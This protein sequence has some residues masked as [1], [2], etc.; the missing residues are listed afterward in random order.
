[1][2]RA[3]FLTSRPNVF[4]SAVF[5]LPLSL[6]DTF[7]RRILDGPSGIAKSSNWTIVRPAGKLLLH[8]LGKH[9]S[10]Y[11]RVRRGF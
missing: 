6:C 3:T 11:V 10:F 1:M 2:H 7:K 5:R 8:C 9:G 4:P